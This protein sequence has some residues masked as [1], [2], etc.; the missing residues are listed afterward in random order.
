[1]IAGRRVVRLVILLAA[2]ATGLG[3]V[4]PTA[5]PASCVGPSITVTGVPTSVTTIQ[6]PDTGVP[7]QVFAVDEG[8]FT[9]TGEWFRTGCADTASTESFGVGCSRAEPREVEVG[10]QDVPLTLTW[11]GTTYPL[12]TSDATGSKYETRWDVTLPAE[13]TD[14]QG[15]AVLTAGGALPIQVDVTG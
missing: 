13:V 8:S 14:G 2:A 6:D 12:G 5:A 15:R 3:L 1:M 10:Q 9:V 7:V 11:N 4:A